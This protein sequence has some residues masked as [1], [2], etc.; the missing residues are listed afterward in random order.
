M[1]LYLLLN[2]YFETYWLIILL[3]YWRILISPRILT[4]D[5]FVTAELCDKKFVAEKFS[6]NCICQVIFSG[7]LSLPRS[8]HSP[9]IGEPRNKRL[10][11]LSSA[12]DDM[13]IVRDKSEAAYYGQSPASLS[14]QASWH[15]DVDHSETLT[16]I[17]PKAKG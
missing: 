12:D 13:E 8:A 16:N 1:L 7:P 10:R 6:Y 4:D 9:G 2:S 15:S 5:L 14:S 17:S 11:R 3:H